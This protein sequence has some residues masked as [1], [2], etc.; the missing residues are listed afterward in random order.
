MAVCALRSRTKENPKQINL[1]SRLTEAE[2][3]S[4]EISDTTQARLN[5][6]ART[7]CSL[8]WIFDSESIARFVRRAAAGL[9]TSDLIISAAAHTALM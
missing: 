9:L 2:T 4:C 7:V 3:S 8:Y 1:G 6:Y 5:G